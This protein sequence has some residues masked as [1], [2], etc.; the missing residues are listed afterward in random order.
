MP[1]T[2]NRKNK[3]KV[4]LAL[5][6]GSALGIAHLG[7]IQ[8]LE[9]NK[10]PIDCLSGTSAG[11]IV[12][13]C[14]AFGVPLKKMAEVTKKLKWT[15]FSR[16]SISKM[17]LMNNSI[18]GET[19][20]DLIGRGP[21]V[22]IEDSPIPLAIVSTDISSGERVVFTKGNLAQAVTASSCIPGLFV[23]V[24]IDGHKLVDGAFVEDVPIFALA[25]LGADIEIGVNLQNF[26]PYLEPQNVLDIFSNVITILTKKQY[27]LIEKS[28]LNTLLIKPHL[29]HYSSS[30]FAKTDDLIAE[31]YRA[32]TLV[33]PEIKNLLEDK[34]T[35]TFGASLLKLFVNL[36]SLKD[37]G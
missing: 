2:K 14:Y 33:I 13:A 32:T 34:E 35:L 10:I 26:H 25:E 36:F 20:I 6:G 22:L 8:A 29:E 23:P 16:L 5:G 12:A 24:E 4:G 30:D 17:G 27:A 28:G 37:K 15:T 3:I 11:A 21:N 18:I 31:G 19:I 1:K 7:V 9:D